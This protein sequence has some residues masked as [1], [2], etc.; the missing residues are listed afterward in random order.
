MLSP[1]TRLQPGPLC[2]G[3]RYIAGTSRVIFIPKDLGINQELRNIYIKG[4][5]FMLE[6]F[7]KEQYSQSKERLLF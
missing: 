2:Q 3:G 4:A 7:W 6:V 1:R 5:L